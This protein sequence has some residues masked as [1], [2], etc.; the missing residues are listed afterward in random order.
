MGLCA[1]QLKTPINTNN[2]YYRKNCHYCI[3]LNFMSGGGAFRGDGDR[4]MG[5]SGKDMGGGLE[6]QVELI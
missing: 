1:I 3:V 6:C 4:L 2:F 5:G